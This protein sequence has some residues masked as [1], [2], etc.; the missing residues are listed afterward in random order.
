LGAEVLSTNLSNGQ[1]AQPLNAAN[2]VKVTIDGSKVFINQA[3]V[4]GADLTTDNGVVHVLNAILLP[5]ETVADIAIGSAAHTTLVAAAIEARLLPALTDPFSELTVFAPTDAAF[6]AALSNLGITAADLLA[7]AELQDILL[8][9]VLGA[10]VLSTNL[11]NGQIAQPLN[12]TN[13]VKVTIDGSKV[14]INQAEVSAADLTADNGVVHVLNSVLLPSETVADIAI[15]SAAH[16]TLV[17]AVIE[18]KLLPALTNPFSE[19]TVFAPTDAAFS[20]LATTLGVAVADILKLPNLKDILL[21]HVVD[22]ALLS[23]DLKTGTVKAI[24]GVNLTIDLTSGVMVNK[25]KVT[26]AD[27]VSDNGVVHVI[28]A[29]ITGPL[30]SLEKVMAANLSMYPNPTTDFINISNKNNAGYAVINVNGAV[31]AN[32]VVSNSNIDVTSLSKGVY[33]LRIMDG[34]TLYLGR[35]IKK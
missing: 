13:T 9:H 30:N 27:L 31:V 6:T 20:S 25:S 11:S 23:K 26:T 12:A 4:T 3:E 21:N 35:F 2:T 29:V 28:D 17:A 24:N 33:T 32:G 22:S 18:A 8:Y 10:E 34:E 1:I 15:G 14:F 7:S 16:T 19:L 5:S